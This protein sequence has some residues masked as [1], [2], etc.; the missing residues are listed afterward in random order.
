M[1]PGAGPTFN[2]HNCRRCSK[3]RRCCRIC[4]KRFLSLSICVL[5]STYSPRLCVPSQRPTH[6]SGLR[7]LWEHAPTLLRTILSVLSNVSLCFETFGPHVNPAL[8]RLDCLMLG[9][10]VRL[11]TF[12]KTPFTMDNVGQEYKSYLKLSAGTGTIDSVPEAVWKRV[13]LDVPVILLTHSPVHRESRCL[14][15]GCGGEGVS[16]DSQ[17]VAPHVF[18]SRR[19]SLGRDAQ[20]S[21][22]FAQLQLVGAAGTNVSTAN[23]DE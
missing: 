22:N 6:C 19:A 9:A 14:A 20:G 21:A 13:R 12:K 8:C 3:T 18:V 17:G 1:G 7:T 15:S 16:A 10:M 2:K 5:F 4:N 11:E 23:C